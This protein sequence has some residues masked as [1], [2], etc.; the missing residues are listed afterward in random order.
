MERVI[1]D[2]IK[3][4][5]QTHWWFVGRR[6]IIEQTLSALNLRQPARIL[7]V[8]CGTGGNIPL[9]Q[10]F[11]EVRAM[12]PD[13]PSREHVQAQYG[14]QADSGFLPDGLPYAPA[15]FDLICA[16]DVIEHVDDDAAAIQALARLLDQGG[17]LLVTVPAYQWMW[18]EHDALHHH[19]RRYRLRPFRA[20]FEAAGLEIVQA[21]YFNALLLPVAVG[22]RMTKKAFGL[23]GEED[24]LPAAP[25]NRLLARVFGAEAGWLRRR[26][27]PA[28]LSI[29]LAARRPALQ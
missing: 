1:Y 29:L 22:V 5:E 2:R 15:S 10:R 23:K 16:F 12:E 4:V 9:L 20:L 14:L 17:V 26:A 3:Q 27:F 21:S 28:G 13:A 18:S 11:G 25:V 24:R 8:G 19:K 7:E 6:R